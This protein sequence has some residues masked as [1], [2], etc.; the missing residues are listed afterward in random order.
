MHLDNNHLKFEGLDVLRGLL[1]ITVCIAHGWQIFIMPIDGL[2]TYIGN[3][4][5]L[6]AR[7]AVLCFF[8]ISGFV[9]ALSIKRNIDKLG[10]F[11]PMEYVASRAF[12]IIPPLL[13]VIALAYLLVQIADFL[14]ISNLPE[15]ITGARTKFETKPNTQLRCLVTLC[16]K[17]EL[18]G[19][20]N[21]PLWSLQYEIQLYVML[22]LLATVLFMKRNFTGR[23]LALFILISYVTAIFHIRDAA[24]N[25]HMQIIWFAIFASGS[26]G[27]IA[28]NKLTTRVLLTLIGIGF[29]ICSILI[30]TYSHSRIMSDLDSSWE[31]ILAQ[32]IF[33]MACAAAIVFMSRKGGNESMAALGKFSYTLYI[34]HFPVFLMTYFLIVNYFPVYSLSIGW[35]ITLCAVVCCILFSNYL[36]KIIENTRAQRDFFR[37]LFAAKAKVLKD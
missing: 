31:L 3:F 32:L 10:D 30:S 28:L 25:F 1:A 5:G 9:V 36:S 29:S 33:G 11:H 24:G 19:I 21:G 18:T 13:F 12:R 2:N 27:L 6:A 16:I 14:E 15:G 20:L 26:F 37:S 23:V 34:L 8:C 22:G 4:L 7:L 17:G 35:V